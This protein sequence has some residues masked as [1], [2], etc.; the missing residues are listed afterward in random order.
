MPPKE[1]SH[2]TLKMASAQVVKMSVTNNSPSQDSNH[3]DDFF[4]SRFLAIVNIAQMEEVKSVQTR[5]MWRIGP[6]KI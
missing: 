6:R 3:P 5:N 2:L 4:Q 1:K